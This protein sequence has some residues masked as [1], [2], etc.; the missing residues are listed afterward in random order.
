[1][2]EMPATMEQAKKNVDPLI[3]YLTSF[4]Y[5]QEKT[6][7]K[8]VSKVPDEFSDYYHYK[9]VFEVKIRVVYISKL[10]KFITSITATTTTYYKENIKSNYNLPPLYKKIAPLPK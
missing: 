4:P 10:C 9:R 3:N 8:E 7:F 6:E 5:Y 1:M 2:G